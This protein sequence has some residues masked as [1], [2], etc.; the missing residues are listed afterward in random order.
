MTS[1]FKY[2]NNNKKLINTSFILYF[3][4]NYDFTNL[5]YIA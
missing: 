1:S 5:K 3:Y 2:F 4:K